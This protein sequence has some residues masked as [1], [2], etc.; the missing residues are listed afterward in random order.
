MSPSSGKMTTGEEP[1]A[2]D[3]LGTVAI[4]EEMENS[5]PW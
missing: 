2:E 5:F 1:T 4:I 3:A